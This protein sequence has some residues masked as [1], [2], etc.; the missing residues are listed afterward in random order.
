MFLYK[1][2][3]V[4]L[5]LSVPV[6]KEV[7]MN[8]NLVIQVAYWSALARLRKVGMNFTDVLHKKIRI[9]CVLPNLA[10]NLTLKGGLYFARSPIKE[11]KEYRWMLRWS[12]ER[13]AH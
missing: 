13:H 3:F 5:R 1:V 12:M 10:N 8:N 9:K 2:V 11:K 4:A 7:D 6:Q